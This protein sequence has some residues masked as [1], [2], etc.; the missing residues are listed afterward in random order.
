MSARKIVLGITGASGAIYA[1]R[2]LEV[3]LDAGCEVQLSISPSG[4]AVFKQE[5]CVDVDA[6]DVGAVLPPQASRPGTLRCF[7]YQDFM[8][9]MASGSAV[10]DGMVVCPCS[11]GTLSAIARGGSDNLIHRAAE[12]HLKERRKLILVPRETPLS[13]PHIEN[14]RLC[15]LAGAIM[16]PASPAF[17]HGAK[18]LDDLVDFVVAR[19]CDQLGIE[20]KLVRRWGGEE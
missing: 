1:R 11:G 14:M 12:V 13:L 16:L 9:P 6:Y 19:I 18:T 7:D 2:L 4:V 17:Y 3:L 5:L 20:Q 8:A 10:S 15:A